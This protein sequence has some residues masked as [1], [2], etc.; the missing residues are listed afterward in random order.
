M[1]NKNNIRA[2]YR[3]DSKTRD[4]ILYFYPEL[5]DNGE[6]LMWVCEKDKDIKYFFDIPFIDDNWEIQQRINVK[7]VDGIEVFENDRVLISYKEFDCGDIIQ[8][9]ATIFID[10]DGVPCIRLANLSDEF[11]EYIDSFFPFTVWKVLSPACNI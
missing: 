9:E 1:I 4:G 2:I 5:V 10:E 3:P 8:D 7:T 6:I 11:S